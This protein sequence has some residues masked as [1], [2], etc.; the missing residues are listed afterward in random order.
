VAGDIASLTQFGT[1]FQVGDGVQISWMSVNA[2]DRQRKVAATA[3]SG[4]IA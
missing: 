1:R 3:S 2:D 4:E